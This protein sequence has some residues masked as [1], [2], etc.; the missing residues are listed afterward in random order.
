MEMAMRF[1]GVV[2]LAVPLMFAAAS[3]SG[4]NYPDKPV[5]L[6]TAEVGGGADS[7]ARLI[8]Q[9]LTTNLGQP[10]VVDNRGG[11]SGA[12]ATQA[13]ARAPADGYTLMLYSSVLWIVPLLQTVPWDMARD[14]APVSLSAHSPNV[15]VVHPSIPVKGVKELI[16]LAKAKPGKLSYA[17]GGVGSS[18]HLAGELFK[19]LAQVDIVRIAYKGIGESI[20]DLIAGQVE[21]SFGA[22][23]S[24]APHVKSGRLKALAVT[25]AQPSLSFPNLPTV[26]ATLPGYAAETIYGIWAPA[27]TPA[28]IIG[29]I[30]AELV[31]VLNQADIKAKLLTFAVEPVAS[32]PDQFAAWIKSDSATMGKLIRD[33]NIHSE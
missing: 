31:R 25:S 2:W 15:L 6:I 14:F 33:A 9:G 27:K 32:T 22:A 11:A 3:A 28:A 20:T 21:M 12:I 19:S 30:N 29:R 18:P 5:H 13:V 7:T 24:V 23:G 1:T 4:Q 8:A 26:A 17:S 10:F 16:A